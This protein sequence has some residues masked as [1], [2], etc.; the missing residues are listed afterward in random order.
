MRNQGLDRA[1]GRRIVESEG[2]SEFPRLDDDLIATQQRTIDL[3]ERD[4][5]LPRPL[6]ADEHFD[7]RFDEVAARAAAPGAGDR[8]DR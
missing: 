8:G 3:L 1:D 4:G 5:G 6:D 7:R 2:P